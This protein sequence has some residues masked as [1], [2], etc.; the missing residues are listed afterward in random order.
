MAKKIITIRE[1]LEYIKAFDDTLK[2]ENMTTVDLF[3]SLLDIPEQEAISSK[4]IVSAYD[5]KR[6]R[7]MTE[8]LGNMFGSNQSQN[9]QLNRNDMK[10]LRN[11]FETHAKEK[12][13][14]I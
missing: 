11:W 14:D 10:D 9:L 8:I 3:R 6:A 2:D 4:K 12:V 7:D 1:K 5:D 13:E